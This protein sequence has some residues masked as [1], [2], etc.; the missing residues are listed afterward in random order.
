MRISVLLICVPLFGFYGIVMSYLACNIT[1]NAVRIYM[2]LRFT[3]LKPD[4]K[5]I[6]L[7]PLIALTVS[8]QISK[9]M[10]HF[11]GFLHM[12][13][14]ASAVLYALICGGLYLLMLCVLQKTADT[15][16]VPG[17]RVIRQI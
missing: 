11:I 16:P 6:L 4:W 7:Y 8:W 10:M 12:N 14:A 5:Q 2:V 3:G 13:G 17:K 15:A 9:L 1:G